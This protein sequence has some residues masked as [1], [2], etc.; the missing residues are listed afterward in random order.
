MSLNGEKPA[1]GKVAWISWV[2]GS[3][4]SLGGPQRYLFIKPWTLQCGTT[5]KLQVAL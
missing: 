3:W 2:D 4:V 1:K 5:N